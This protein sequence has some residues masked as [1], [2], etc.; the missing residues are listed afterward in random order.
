MASNNSQIRESFYFYNSLLYSI[1][2]LTN[3][4][5]KVEIFKNAGLVVVT[6]LCQNKAKVQFD[7]SL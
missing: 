5:M 7:N 1:P 2:I 3:F 6:K 4:D